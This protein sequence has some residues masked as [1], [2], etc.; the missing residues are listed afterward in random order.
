MVRN[1][2]STFA[3]TRS[4]RGAVQPP[5]D[6]RPGQADHGRRHRQDVHVADASPRNQLLVPRRAP[7]SSWCRRSQLLNQSLH[8]WWPTPRPRFRCAPSRSRSDFH[9][10]LERIRADDSRTCRGRGPAPSSMTDPARLHAIKAR[11]PRTPEDKLTVVLSIYQSHRRRRRKPSNLG[12]CFYS[13][14]STHLRRGT[15]DDRGNRGRPGRVR[16]RQ[17]SRQ[18]SAAR[19]EAAVHEP[20]RPAC[21]YDDSNWRWAR[22]RPTPCSPPW[23]MR[24]STGSSCTARLR[25]GSRGSPC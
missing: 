6:R 2:R 3:R 11:E 22:A 20:R 4:P 10:R 24:R 7:C 14:G 21:L 8:E 19:E 9:G 5:G 18:C 23:T 17:G 1:D 15:P 12:F 25:R 16:L 13:L